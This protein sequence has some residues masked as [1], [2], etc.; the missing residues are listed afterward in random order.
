[1]SHWVIYKWFLKDVQFHNLDVSVLLVSLLVEEIDSREIFNG[2]E[3]VD[4]NTN[5]T[6]ACLKCGL[7]SITISHS[8]SIKH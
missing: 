7:S 4:K 3:H 2:I 8:S 1:M 6:A 5:I